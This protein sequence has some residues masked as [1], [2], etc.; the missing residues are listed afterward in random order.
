[1]RRGIALIIV[2]VRHRSE[3]APPRRRPSG[4]TRA[5][6]LYQKGVEA[7]NKKDFETA[8]RLAGEAIQQYGTHV[9]AYYLRGQAAIAQSKW[10]AAAAALTKVN[11]L[12]PTSFAGQRDPRPR[13]STDGAH[14]RRDACLQGGARSA[15]RSGRPVGASGVHAREGKPGR[16]RRADP[17]AARRQGFEDPRG[18]GSAR[19]DR[20]RA[21]RV[22]DH[23]E[24]VH[25]RALPA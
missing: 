2:G 17:A 5:F 8:D 11:E 4:T 13:V 7:L 12:Y 10:E 20:L 15:S 9:L 25:A 23:R 16:S 19:T 14:R 6:A 3:S 18:L 1:M 22:R 21:G 24:G